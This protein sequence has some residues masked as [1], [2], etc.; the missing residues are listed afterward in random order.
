MTDVF[1]KYLQIQNMSSS[2]D[3]SIC[4]VKEHSDHVTFY[5]GKTYFLKRNNGGLVLYIYLMI[6]V[7]VL[8]IH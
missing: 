6:R 1:C 5:T 7:S 4:P 3:Y 8:Q 2:H